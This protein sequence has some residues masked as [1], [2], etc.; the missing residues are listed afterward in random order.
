LTQGLSV[1]NPYGQLSASAS[2]E[3]PSPSPSPS[4]PAAGGNGKSGSLS[5]S[6]TPSVSNQA[7]PCQ[8][9]TRQIAPRARMQAPLLPPSQKQ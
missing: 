6:H 8:S 5:M 4:P 9:P 1:F 7:T 3:L 2:P